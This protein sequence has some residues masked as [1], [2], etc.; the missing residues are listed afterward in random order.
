[1]V[2]MVF[3]VAM[4]LAPSVIYIDDIDKVFVSA[5]SKK[6]SDIVKMKNFILQHKAALT[7]QHRVLVIGN[8]RVPFRKLV[9]SLCVDY[10]K[11]LTMVSAWV[12]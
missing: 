12:W 8:S 6:T 11:L 7:R 10:I 4:D 1:M 3:Q 9:P 5:K 2:H